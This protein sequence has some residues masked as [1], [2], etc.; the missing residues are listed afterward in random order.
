MPISCGPGTARKQS[1]HNILQSISFTAGIHN[2][3]Y[4]ATVYSILKTSLL[5]WVLIR[6]Y[7]LGF[8][9]IS[10][11]L[12]SWSRW[13][14]LC[15]ALLDL[16]PRYMPSPATRGK[17]MASKWK[18]AQIHGKGGGEI[19]RCTYS[20]ECTDKICILTLFRSWLIW[21][22]WT[23]TCMWKKSALICP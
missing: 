5:H 1:K 7:W 14:D 19:L 3:K 11:W 4:C 10:I 12:G 16:A 9:A 18:W 21:T 15:I 22:D 20:N 2:I 13:S 17:C 23:V 8:S 6:T